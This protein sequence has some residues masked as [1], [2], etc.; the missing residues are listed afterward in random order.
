MK[1]QM[2][3]TPPPGTRLPFSRKPPFLLVPH[4]IARRR[5]SHTRTRQIGVIKYTHRRERDHLQAGVILFFLSKAKEKARAKVKAKEK[6][7]KAKAKAI[8]KAKIPK[9]RNPEA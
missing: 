2:M 4:P 1:L 6:E 9:A 7:S 5:I 3:K 8:A